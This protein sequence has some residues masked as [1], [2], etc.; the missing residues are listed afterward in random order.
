V[1][2]WTQI[3][4]RDHF[5]VWHLKLSLCRQIL[6]VCEVK[7][8]WDILIFRSFESL[9]F[10][11]LGF[12]NSFRSPRVGFGLSCCR[13]A[14]TVWPW[15]HCADLFFF[16]RRS[17]VLVEVRRLGFSGLPQLFGNSLVLG[18]RIHEFILFATCWFGLSAGPLLRVALGI[19]CRPFFGIPRFDE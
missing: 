6:P 11:V 2:V 9:G 1:L 14:S 19:V 4:T 12:A 10:R 15:C 17:S 3:V 13:T 16:W 8:G 5:T 7:R 18:F